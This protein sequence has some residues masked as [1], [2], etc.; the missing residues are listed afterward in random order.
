MN[1]PQLHD[2]IVAIAT[3][4]RA[5]PMGLVRLSGD[6]AFEL[7]QSVVASP[8]RNRPARPRRIRAHLRLFDGCDVPAEILEF[9]G[10]RSYTGQDVCEIHTIGAPPLLR[11]LCDVLVRRGARPAQPGEFTARAYLNQKLTASQVGGVLELIQ[12]Q[13]A[14]H[15]RRAAR[16]A[17][18]L[19]S[20]RLE[21]LRAELVELLGCVEAGIDFVEEDGIAFITPSALRARLLAILGTCDELTRA[22]ESTVHRGLPH[23]ALVGRPN[24]GKSSLFNALLGRARAIT[25]P[26]AGTTRDVISAELNIATVRVVLQDCAG[27]GRSAEELSQAAHVAAE[28]TGTEADLV[29]WVHAVDQPWDADEIA[30]AERIGAQRMVLVFTKSDLARSPKEPP[31]T[32]ESSLCSRSEITLS[33]SAQTGDGL[34]ALRTAVSSRLSRTEPPGSTTQAVLVAREAVQRA[35]ELISERDASLTSPELTA[36]ALREAHQGL[37]ERPAERLDEQVLGW[38]YSSFCIGK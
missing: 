28:R 36:E 7:A 20:R 6:N 31:I 15:L 4:L 38:I 26:W 19:F 13:D 2:C 22:G 16:L 10:P 34:D 37:A 29:L 33:V 24:A 8:D 5:A 9:P 30:A 35:L 23:V 14:V 17:G 25:S 18:G 32:V 11:H 12:A 21:L 3:G 1:R 27:L